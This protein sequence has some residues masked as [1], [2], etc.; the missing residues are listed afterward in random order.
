MSWQLTAGRRTC[1]QCAQWGGV[2]APCTTYAPR[3]VWENC[4]GWVRDPQ[5]RQ[6]VCAYCAAAVAIYPLRHRQAAA[7]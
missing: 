7:A 1:T 4:T 6:A 5:D 2:A 3:L